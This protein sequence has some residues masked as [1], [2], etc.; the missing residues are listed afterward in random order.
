MIL[1]I[2]TAA[3]FGGIA[4]YSIRRGYVPV[5][6]RHRLRVRREKYPLGFWLLVTMYLAVAGFCFWMFVLSLRS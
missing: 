2:F 3:L 6:Q 5:G 1:L 4:V